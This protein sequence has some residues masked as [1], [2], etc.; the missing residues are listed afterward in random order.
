MAI[1]AGDAIVYLN[2]D[3]KG[4]Q[5]AWA[6]A[7][8]ETRINLGAITS[9]IASAGQ[10]M[11]NIGNSVTSSAKSIAK[12][13][14][15]TAGVFATA[16]LGILKMQSDFETAF[17][18][19]KKTVDATDEEFDDLRQGLI[20]M[21]KTMP[22]SA[23]DL[24]KIMEAAGQ[25][26]VTGKDNLLAFTKT[27]AMLGDTTNLSSEDAATALAQFINLTGGAL[28]DVERL[29]SV[30]VDLG[31]NGASTEA[32]IMAMA[33][34]IAGAGKTAGLTQQQI[35]ALAN[36]SASM[37][38]EAEA[39]G[40]AIS[41][42]LVGMAE[43]GEYTR[44]IANGTRK[45]EDFSDVQQK[46]IGQFESMAEAVG[47]SSG[48]FAEMVRKDPAKALM[49]LTK[50]LADAKTT[51]GPVF[52][53]LQE[54]GVDEVRL[55][56]TVLAMANG[57][58]VFNA[59]LARSDQA[60]RSNTA[61]QE[62]AR[63]KYETFTNTL[64]IAW[65]NFKAIVLQVSDAV[66]PKLTSVLKEKVIPLFQTWANYVSQNSEQIKTSVSAAVDW[67]VQ[68]FDALVAWFQQPANIAMIKDWGGKA[69]NFLK[70]WGPTL[71]KL[72][73]AALI[74]GPILSAV[75][76]L[77]IAFSGMIKTVSNLSGWLTKIHAFKWQT[78]MRM[79][80]DGF[81]AL[82]GIVTSVFGF[83]FSSAGAITAAIA[84]IAAGLSAF[85]QMWTTGDWTKNWISEAIDKYFPMLGDA[86]DLMFDDIVAWVE[87]VQ[88]WFGSL[89]Q[90]MKDVWDK[91]S[92]SAVWDALVQTKN[93][94]FDWVV[95]VSGKFGEWLSG[96]W[97]ATKEWF[98]KV[99]SAIS[100][101][102]A[103]VFDWIVANVTNPIADKFAWL[104][105][106]SKEWFGK[107]RDTVSDV[108]TDVKDAIISAF[109]SVEDWVTGWV[110][111]IKNKIKDVW[112][113]VKDAFGFGEQFNGLA[114][115]RAEE[116][117]RRGRVRQYGRGTDFHPG[118]PAILGD[119]G[120]ELA[121]LPRGTRVYDNAETQRM[122]G[123]F[124]WGGD[125]NV[126]Q[127]PGED[128]EALAQRIDRLIDKK[129][130]DAQRF[131]LT[132]GGWAA[133]V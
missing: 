104:W 40:S 89:W 69:L 93:D 85:I 53:M 132:R 98:G 120:P 26:G 97:T 116:Y 115:G 86:I 20:D 121:V 84:G 126:Y 112:A 15:G 33:L 34:R 123:G 94:I 4:F 48:A 41:K 107:I 101:A 30:L 19:V 17:S 111:R 79:A 62:E 119:R 3:L 38:I 114:G 95:K 118:G 109:R 66:L 49:A 5:R 6:Q 59:S 83:I 70:E 108:F 76:N 54:M 78:W 124:Q 47:M 23:A 82:R 22:Q 133:A 91:F 16:G 55:R 96:V 110:S 64:R 102:L 105:G 52:T 117:V 12:W 131:G 2:A 88:E 36:A 81:V 7:K 58:D 8:R 31:N 39:G 92:K 50:A 80:Y 103:P 129:I 28:G 128:G 29:G 130:L 56:Q 43:G 77:T 73:G 24:A 61:L 21:S 45:M 37:G 106:K 65:N 67:A 127:R 57:Q 9:T 74:F 13:G 87:S 75:G 1:S 11:V 35:L 71:L 113:S 42:M 68:K 10:G 44:A 90:S 27:A 14:L 25:L 51:G 100:D 63:K 99:A 32:D 18:G 125:I 60:F 72:E 122:L 46:T